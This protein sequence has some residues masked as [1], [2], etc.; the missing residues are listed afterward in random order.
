MVVV[1]GGKRTP[2]LRSMSPG[3]FFVSAVSV[4][5]ESNLVACRSPTPI[6]SY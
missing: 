6:H 2:L 5:V 3:P 4:I 1:P